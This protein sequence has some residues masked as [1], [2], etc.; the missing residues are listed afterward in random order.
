MFCPNCGSELDDNAKFCDKCGYSMVEEPQYEEP[1][2]SEPQYAEPQYTESQYT[3][4]QYDAAQYEEPQ[5]SV[6][7]KKFHIPKAIPI[8]IGAVAGVA[9]IGFG[10]YKVAGAG[11]SLFA[12]PEEYNIIVEEKFIEEDIAALG[13]LYGNF[14]DNAFDPTDFSVNVAASWNI[15]DKAMDMI[16]PYIY[17]GIRYETDMDIDLSAFSKFDSE[18]TINSKDKDFSVDASVSVGGNKIASAEGILSFSEREAFARIPEL[19]S[20]YIGFNFASLTSEIDDISDQFDQLSDMLD[21]VK[22]GLP[23]SDKLQKLVSSYVMTALGQIEDVSQS[24]EEIEVSGVSQKVTVLSYDINGKTLANMMEAVLKKAQKD[25]ELKSIIE[26]FVGLA[27]EINKMQYGEYYSYYYREADPDEVYEEFVEEIAE[28]LD[29]LDDFKDEYGKQKLVSVKVYVGKDDKVVGHEFTVKQEHRVYRAYR[30]DEDVPKNREYDTYETT[31]T[32]GYKIANSGKNE[33]F[34]A[35]YSMKSD[36]EKVSAEV[37]GSGTVADDKLSGKYV[38]KL[39]H[40]QDKYQ[41]LDI[42]LNNLDKAALKKGEIIGSFGLSLNSKFEDFLDEVGLNRSIK[43]TLRYLEDAKVVVDVVSTANK[44]SLAI[45]PT[46][47]ST[48]LGTVSLSVT[49]DKGK[50]ISTPSSSNVVMIRLNS[51]GEP[52]MNSLTEYFEDAKLSTI[53]GSL[54]KLN[55]SNEINTVLSM[56]ENL[57]IMDAVSFFI[58]GF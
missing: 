29:D 44:L 10:V 52:D 34:S 49:Q 3:E 35:Y 22:N 24:K 1:Q 40:D 54:K 45:S 55:L 23:K 25:K 12:K 16:M 27:N 51:Y 17:E 26:E 11:K 57:S 13:A 28:L 38:V 42:E 15:S 50:K 31:I 46:Y 32:L 37:T 4:P 18:Y 6:P 47:D 8:A 21:T 33:G 14:V 41:L 2:Y 56:I 58:R 5:F 48:K 20:K 30:S 43:S 19:S 53:V 36:D 39:S 7:K 9:A